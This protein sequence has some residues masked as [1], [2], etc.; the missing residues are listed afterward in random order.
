MVLFSRI[1][2]N[3]NHPFSKKIINQIYKTLKESSIEYEI[4]K[5]NYSFIVLSQITQTDHNFHTASKLV[6][7]FPTRRNSFDQ[8]ALA[9]TVSVTA[10]EPF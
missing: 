1:L 5:L 9:Y 8:T 4:F 10:H 6:H 7:N 3:M 2:Q